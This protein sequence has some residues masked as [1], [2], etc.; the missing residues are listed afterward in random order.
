MTLW[1]QFDHTNLN[2][3]LSNWSDYTQ[4]NQVLTLAAQH[5]HIQDNTNESPQN[6]QEEHQYTC[7]ITTTIVLTLTPTQWTVNNSYDSLH[8]RVGNSIA[9]VKY[10]LKSTGL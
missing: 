10:I 9:V 7:A 5:M 1:K 8:A 4:D 3:M 2:D 6:L